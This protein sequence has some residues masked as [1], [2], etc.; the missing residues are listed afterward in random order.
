MAFGVI[1]VFVIAQIAWWTFFQQ[2]YVAEVSRNT[3]AGLEREATD[4]SALLAMGARAEVEELLTTSPHL[5]LAEGGERVE[6]DA[7]SLSAFHS[8]QRSAVRMFAFEGPFFALV[9]MA[10]LF[11]IG[12]SLRLERELKRRQSNFLDAMGHEYKTPISTLRLLLETLQLRALPAPKQQ[13]YLQRMGEEIDRLERTGQQ[14][15]AT[16]HLEA[17]AP[18]RQPG[19]HDLSSLVRTVVERSRAGL[20]AR[21][22]A[23]SLVGDHEPLP[24]LADIEDV[25]ILVENLLDNAVKYTPGPEK[26]VKVRVY[27]EGATAVLAVE[28][29]GRGIPKRQRALVFE[30]FYRVG[31]ELTRSASGLGLGLHLV[32]LTAVAR[33]GKVTIEEVSGGGTRVLVSLPLQAPAQGFAAAGQEAVA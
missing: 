11:I 9:V 32:H 5:R 26:A 6:V 16:A 29:H 14:V 4:L 28:D 17:G 22:A 19:L 12:R 21:G 10:G 20:E 7:A 24:V 2:R 18:Q 23:L 1:I 27:R 25:T 15:I 30:R 8:K 3:A 13:E 31:D 33:G